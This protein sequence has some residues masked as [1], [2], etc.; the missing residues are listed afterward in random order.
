MFLQ[1]SP[2][3]AHKNLNLMAQ[4]AMDVVPENPFSVMFSN[5]GHRAVHIPKHTVLGLA[6]PS[7]THILTLGES[8]AEAAKAKERGG[9][10]NTNPSAAEK[11][12]GEAVDNC[13]DRGGTEQA[14]PP[15][16][17]L[18]ADGPDKLEDTA[19]TEEDPKSWQEDV[20]IGAEDE[21]VRSEV[22]EV[23][24]EF[25]DMWTGRLGKIGATKHRIEL[26]PDARPIDQEP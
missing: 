20:H 12:A 6:L 25:K 10:F 24:S 15:R 18:G 7:P 26:K 19:A 3:T 2:E 17:P 13:T 9:I 1:N 22:L 16:A 8:A 11:L 21:E 23:L 5:F 14:T 4:G